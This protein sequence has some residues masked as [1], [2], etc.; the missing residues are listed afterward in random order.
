MLSGLSG[1]YMQ[2]LERR[3]NAEDSAITDAALMRA[4]AAGDEKAFRQLMQRHLASTVRFAARIVGSVAMAEDVA[5][6]AFLRVWRHAARFEDPETRGA[7]FS[8]WLGRIVINLCIDEKRKAR[9]DNID[10][11]PEPA[12]SSPGA[13]KKL[14][15]KEQSA[16]VR[17]A[18]MRL[19]ERQRTAFILC[20]Y[21]EYSNKEAAD[22]MGISVKAIESLL[23]RSRKMLR[24]LLQQERQV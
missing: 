10:D 19:P 18:L 4:V 8:T 7:K 11:M 13:E 6:E 5:Q 15:Q 20:F 17:Q 22:L 23:V 9:F 16:R 3:Q 2:S 12:D 21:E 14:Q 24:D 1:M